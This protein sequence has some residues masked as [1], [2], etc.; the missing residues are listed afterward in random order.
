MRAFI[1]FWKSFSSRTFSPPGP[2]HC[3]T[4]FAP[5][6]QRTCVSQDEWNLIL[7][8][9][10]SLLQKWLNDY[11]LKSYFEE[12]FSDNLNNLFI[13]ISTSEF[14]SEDAKVFIGFYFCPRKIAIVLAV[15][16]ISHFWEQVS[17]M[18]IS[19]HILNRYLDFPHWSEYWQPYRTYQENRNVYGIAFTVQYRVIIFLLLSCFFYSH[20]RNFHYAWRKLKKDFY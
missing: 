13:V 8:L 1:Q 15:S 3:T 16:V 17:L 14:I 6:K 20:K 10:F 2:Y 12:S 5:P 11:L 19:F 9:K 7:I 18:D 4:S